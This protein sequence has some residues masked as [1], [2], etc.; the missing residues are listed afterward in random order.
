MQF[1]L[2][3]LLNTVFR[4]SRYLLVFW[5]T[6][7]IFMTVFYTQTGKMYESSAKLLIS[8]G[9]EAQG[10]AEYLNGKN[11]QLL[12]RDQQIHNEQQIIESHDVLLTAAKWILGD[13]TPGSPRPSMEPEIAEA[14]PFLTHEARERTP[15]LRMT[16]AVVKTAGKLTSKPQTRDEQLQD[17]VRELSKALTVKAIYDSDA[18]D[19]SFKYRDPRVAQTIL[20]LIIAAYLDHHIAVFQSG[21]ESRMLQSQLDQ[22]VDAYRSHLADF[23]KY[24]VEHH[25]YNDDTQIN[26]LLD[27][28]EKIEQALTDAVAERDSVSARLA[29][30]VSFGPTLQ[31][32]ERYSTT[33]VRNKLYDDLS[34]KLNEENLQEKLLLTRHPVG[35]RAYAEEQAKM[36]EIHHQLE[37]TPAQV[38]DRTED[39]R[40]KASE[41]VDSE[42]IS[43]RELQR[44]HDARIK[45]LWQSRYAL[46]EEIGS[47]AKDL[48]G[49]NTIKLDVAFSKLGAEQ[50][51]Q[52][53]VDSHLRTLTSQNAITD[54]SVID[55][56]TWDYHVAS[57]TT[58]AIAAAAAG[59]FVLGSL[60]IILGLM[61]LDTTFTEGKTAE[62][63]LGAPVVSILPMMETPQRNTSYLDVVA[64]ENHRDFARMFQSIGGTSTGN[65]IFLAETNRG[66]GGSLI[67]YGLSSFIANKMARKSAFLDCTA[68]ALNDDRPHGSSGNAPVTLLHWP[69]S[70]PI[71]EHGRTEILPF[72]EKLRKEY[73]YIVIASGPVKDATDLLTIGDSVTKTFLIVEAA[74][75]RRAVARYSLGLL[76]TYGFGKVGLI[77][78]KRIF[79]VPNWLMRYV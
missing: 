74:K 9:A 33:Q 49:F 28:R 31:S 29:A 14:R 79:Y 18:L 5:L 77:L 12:Q 20:R 3:D 63:R 41:L 58:A 7:L 39:R 50:M 43:L 13:P 48:V 4:Y 66:E 70:K 55:G 37:Q 56:P 65:L 64:R 51:N 2:R 72:L 10:K 76:N 73:D 69:E 36:D 19:V 24:M 40:S 71:R 6:L 34:T 42:T 27:Q 32:T 46:D 15:L 21:P 54:V 62:I 52:A 57:P 45:H 75:T 38:V 60:A 17:I 25:V 23:S 26:L 78:N 44:G 16:S 22:S 53:T 30:I 1:T 11:L 61:G 35:S 68:E 59:L 67:G 47:Y 8:L